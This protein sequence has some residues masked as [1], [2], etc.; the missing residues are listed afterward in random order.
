MITKLLISMATR[1]AQPENSE[2]LK[3]SDPTLSFSY[4]TSYDIAKCRKIEKDL[5]S[6]DSASFSKALF[7]SYI[8]IQK[9]LREK[10]KEGLIQNLAE[11]NKLTLLWVSLL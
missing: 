6:M 2:N 10:D 8:K 7:V 3:E 9:A 1:F 11:L 5:T 4:I